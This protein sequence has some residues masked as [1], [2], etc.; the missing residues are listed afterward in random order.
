MYGLGRVTGHL[1]FVGTCLVFISISGLFSSLVEKIQSPWREEAQV[2][3][4]KR[5]DRS[6]DKD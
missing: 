4:K 5:A 2:L 3:E 6:S 1:V